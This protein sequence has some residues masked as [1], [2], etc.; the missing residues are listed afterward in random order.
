MSSPYED[1]AIRLIA[2]RKEQLKELEEKLQ[3]DPGWFSKKTLT[4]KIKQY[5]KDIEYLQT[6]IERYRRAVSWLRK[7]GE[8]SERVMKEHVPKPAEQGEATAGH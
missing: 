8:F 2:L 4:K 6:E 5:K 3:K 1:D 7:T